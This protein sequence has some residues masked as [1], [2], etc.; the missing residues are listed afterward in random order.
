MKDKRNTF[1]NYIPLSYWRKKSPP[2]SDMTIYSG[3]NLYHLKCNIFPFTVTVKP[4]NKPLAF[5][6]F[7]LQCPFDVQFV[8]HQ[9]SEKFQYMSCIFFCRMKK[10]LTQ[11]KTSWKET[12]AY[13][14]I[15][16]QVQNFIIGQVV[17]CYSLLPIWKLML[18]NWSL[19][20]IAPL[21]TLFITA[22]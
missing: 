10:H 3:A 12:E 1:P 21:S 11:Y 19:C 15:T 22:S 2:Y 6:S 17:T 16:M 18:L 9:L 5:P 7:L 14:L 20:R 8:L 4:E 13:N